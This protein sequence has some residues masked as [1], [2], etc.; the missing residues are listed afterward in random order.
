MASTT[1]TGGFNYGTQAQP[2]KTASRTSGFYYGARTPD[3]ETLANGYTYVAT[4]VQLEAVLYSESSVSATLS[5][6]A[7]Q[8]S[9]GLHRI[10]TEVLSPYAEPSAGLHRL[11]AEVLS[12]FAEIA[13]KRRPVTFLIL[14]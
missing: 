3:A 2:G 5:D 14:D 12:P 10:A 4:P 6:A 7:V 1:R 8:V 11:V 9:A 13:T